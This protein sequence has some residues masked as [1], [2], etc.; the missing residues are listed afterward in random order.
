MKKCLYAEEM[1]N[2]L[3]LIMTMGDG[4][5]L[6]AGPIIVDLVDLYKYAKDNGYTDICIVSAYLHLGGGK[7]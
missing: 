1:R 6:K 2:D 5:L 7:E 3:F 4:M